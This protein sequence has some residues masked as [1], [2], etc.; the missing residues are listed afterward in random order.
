MAF[1][2]DSDDVKV[3]PCSYR[4]YNTTS[5][6]TMVDPESRMITESN[7]ANTTG[8][9]FYNTSENTDRGIGDT[10]IISHVN[11]ILKVV[12]AGYYFEISNVTTPVYGQDPWQYLYINPGQISIAENMYTTRVLKTVD[13]DATLNLDQS[14][15]FKGLLAS[16]DASQ[17]FT[18]GLKVFNEVENPDTH[19]ITYE[20]NTRMQRIHLSVNDLNSNS[21][22]IL[23]TN[24]DAA[25]SGNG[26]NVL[27]QDVT[28][29]RTM[30]GGNKDIVVPDYGSGQ[31]NH[32]LSVNSAG[33]GLEWRVPYTDALED[34]E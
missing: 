1:Y 28:I 24:G 32:V 14:G 19:E 21:G 34:G 4:G 17:T 12:I 29:K 26:N 31:A 27:A 30:T 22:K 16:E 10:Y 23:T 2:F 7:Y 6:D 13:N 9:N 11:N 15:K 25:G 3:F 8:F 18:I 5:N 33:T 20:L